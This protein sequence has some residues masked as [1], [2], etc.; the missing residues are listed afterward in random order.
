MNIKV[1]FNGK[2]VVTENL[3]LEEFLKANGIDPSRRDIGI[4]LNNEV[5]P[6]KNWNGI[7]I[8]NGDSIEVVKIVVGG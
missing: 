5:I 6:K 1:K 8:K 4:A 7:R 2:E 3:S